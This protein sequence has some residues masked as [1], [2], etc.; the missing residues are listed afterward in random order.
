MPELTGRIEVEQRLSEQ[1]RLFGVKVL[2]F[3]RQSLR[4]SIGCRSDQI[5][6]LDLRP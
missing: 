2:V 4:S 3:E 5:P 1:D 6:T